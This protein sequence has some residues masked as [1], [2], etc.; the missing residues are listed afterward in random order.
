MLVWHLGNMKKSAYTL[1][2]LLVVIACVALLISILAPMLGKVR[3]QS[4][5][6]KCASNIR[7]LLGLFSLYQAS[8]QTMPRG[9]FRDIGLSEPPEGYAGYGHIDREGWWW[10]NYLGSLYDDKNKLKNSILKCPSKR[11]YDYTFQNDLLCGNYGVNESICRT[12]SGLL[13]H[14]EFVGEPLNLDTMKTPGQTLLIVDAGY[15]LVNWRHAVDFPPFSLNSALVVGTNYVPGLSINKS[16][17]F[18]FAQ[19]QDAMDGRHPHMTVNVGYA[20]FH[21]E[22]KKAEQLLV[23]KKNDCYFNRYPLWAPRE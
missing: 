18:R 21:L 4:K 9:F 23:R 22:R 8:Y 14:D 2:E 10:F 19:K 13:S 1:I 11:L 5:A 6:I 16:R 20:D 17:N 3:E 12:D 15:T 7:Q